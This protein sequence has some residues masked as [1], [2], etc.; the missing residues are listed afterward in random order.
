MI[1][2]RTSYG[3][4]AGSRVAKAIEAAEEWLQKMEKGLPELRK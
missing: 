3:G 4:T 2:R 1:D